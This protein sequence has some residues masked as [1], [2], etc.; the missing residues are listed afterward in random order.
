M[1]PNNKRPNILFLFSDQFNARCLSIAGHPD[2]QTP[3]LDRLANEGVRF[4]NA[5]VQNPLCTPS[6]MCI[7]SGLYASTHGYYGLYGQE[8]DQRLSR[9]QQAPGAAVAP[10]GGA[11]FPAHRTVTPLHLPGIPRRPPPGQRIGG[12][13]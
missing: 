2:V 13:G 1:T 4:E 11:G 7:L 9:G 5:Y 12:A 10:Q 8:P 3:N 6:R